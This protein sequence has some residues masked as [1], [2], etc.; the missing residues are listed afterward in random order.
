MIR[1]AAA[2]DIPA[3]IAMGAK[4]HEAAGLSEV[5]AFDAPSFETT[6]RGLITGQIPGGLLVTGAAPIGM[7][8]FMAFPAYF[9]FAVTMAQEVFWWV[10][11]EE[12]FGVGAQ[13]LDAFEA[14][15]AARGASVF[16]VA[17]IARLRSDA[18]TRFYARRGYAP[19]E[20]S[21]VKRVT[22]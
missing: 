2:D 19:G 15:A 8:G 12:R 10:E 11:P 3:V 17:A 1:P 22:A 16:I 6:A 7:I 9:N 18:L 13:L 4:F 5:A 21:F 20:N 14:A